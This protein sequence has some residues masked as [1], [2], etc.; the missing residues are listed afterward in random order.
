MTPDEII[1][2]HIEKNHLSTTK[3]MMAREVNA[4]KKTPNSYVAREL[5]C[6]FLVRLHGTTAHFYII[7]G[8]SAKGYIRA[9]K[10]LLEEL[11]KKGVKH[12]QMRVQD[13]NSAMMIGR[14]VGGKNI[15]FHHTHPGRTDSYM[16]VMEI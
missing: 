12:I 3:Q 7:N 10:K 9:V 13:Q 15:R 6:L 5:D 2:N 16:M 4:F 8:G 1:Q 14:S 11:K